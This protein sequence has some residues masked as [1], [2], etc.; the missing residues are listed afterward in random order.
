[1]EDFANENVQLNIKI[2]ELTNKLLELQNE[3]KQLKEDYKQL[4]EDY[5]KSYMQNLDFLRVYDKLNI[6][7]KEENIYDTEKKYQSKRIGFR[8]RNLQKL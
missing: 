5:T 8:I 4:K 7:K 2:N 3:Y 6:E 1:M